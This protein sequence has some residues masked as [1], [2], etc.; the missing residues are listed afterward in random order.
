[1]VE[2]L[3]RISKSAGSAHST[4]EERGTNKKERKEGN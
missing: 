4:K 3:P 2:S 1:M